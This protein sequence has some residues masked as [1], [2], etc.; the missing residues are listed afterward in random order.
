[1]GHIQAKLF[2][3]SFHPQQT[4]S[5]FNYLGLFYTNHEWIGIRGCHFEAPKEETSKCKALSL[6]L[7]GEN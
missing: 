5:S 1:L 7:Y 3:M 4:L 2:S 6:G